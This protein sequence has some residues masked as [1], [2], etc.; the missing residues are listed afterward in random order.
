MFSS[1]SS[2]FQERLGWMT[3]EQ[4]FTGLENGTDILNYILQGKRDIWNL[5]L[6]THFI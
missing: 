1:I 4:S 6:Y 5:L 2:Y 3:S